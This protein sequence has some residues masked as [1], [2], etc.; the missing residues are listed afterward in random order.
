[1]NLVYQPERNNLSFRCVLEVVSGSLKPSVKCV[2]RVLLQDVGAHAPVCEFTFRLERKKC[3]SQNIY[4]AAASLAPAP[5]YGAISAHTP[6]GCSPV[7][8]PSSL[9][10]SVSRKKRDTRL[11]CEVG[12][13][14]DTTDNRFGGNGVQK[15]VPGPVF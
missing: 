15:Q 8:S 13:Q 2:Q 1:M 11:S 7:G 10:P 5:P 6:D 3:I 9:N 12:R 4:L 14:N